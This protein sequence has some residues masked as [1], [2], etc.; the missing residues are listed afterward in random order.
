MRICWP[1]VGAMGRA[2]W[3]MSLVLNAGLPGPPHLRPSQRHAA[4]ELEAL[5]QRKRL[6]QRDDG[7]GEE[8]RAL[9]KR[10]R[11][12][13]RDLEEGDDGSGEEEKI[14]RTL[15]VRDDGSGEERALDRRAVATQVDTG[16]K[17]SNCKFTSFW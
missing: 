7:S 15:A 6:T 5:V 14:E 3:D 1:T 10:M 11:A 12:V 9:V 17:Y 2:I 13:K 16:K 8:E 4:R